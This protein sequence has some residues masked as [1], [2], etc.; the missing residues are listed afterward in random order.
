M[1]NDY[2]TSPDGFTIL[3]FQKFLS[4]NK[5]DIVEAITNFSLVGLY[6]KFLVVLP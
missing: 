3:F 6:Q 2:V 4:I 5:E 1:K